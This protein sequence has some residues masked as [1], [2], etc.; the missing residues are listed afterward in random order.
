V[1]QGSVV[2][3]EA[4]V[5]TGPRI[6]DTMNGIF[7]MLKYGLKS[8]FEGF[9]PNIRNQCEQTVIGDRKGVGG[10]SFEPSSPR[11]DAVDELATLMTAGRLS[12]QTC[13]LVK[14][15]YSGPFRN[16]KEAAIQAQ[17]LIAATPEFHTTTTVQPTCNNRAKKPAPSVSDK[18][19]KALVYILLKGGYDSY[20]MLVPQTCTPTNEAGKNL[21]EQYLD[22][23]TTIALTEEERIRIIQATDGQQPC[24][25]FAVHPEMELLERLYKGGDLSF[26]ANVGQIDTPVTKD[27]YNQKTR[28]QLF[29]HNTMQDEAQ[30]LDPWD[31]TSG[32]GILGRMCDALQA[33]GF[34]PQPLTVCIRIVWSTLSSSPAAHFVSC[35]TNLC[36]LFCL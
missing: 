7:S 20:N 29:A 22:E 27:D 9:G 16:Q 30:R 13:R 18:P 32:T 28:T 15:V 23:R 4:Q 34:N 5:L 25:E 3:P 6:I 2:A 11:G 33:K 24:D 19:Y 10:M 1:S 17:M 12:P 21:L 36:S 35:C 8:C 31:T 14:T 26:F